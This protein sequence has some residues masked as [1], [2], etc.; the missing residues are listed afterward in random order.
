MVTFVLGIVWAPCSSWPFQDAQNSIWSWVIEHNVCCF[1]WL[2]LWFILLF[3][4]FLLVI[5]LGGWWLKLLWFYFCSPPKALTSLLV[6]LSPKHLFS[7]EP[8]S[9]F[10]WLS[11]VLD[12]GL[13]MGTWIPSF[14]WG[15]I[16]TQ[17]CCQEGA[18]YIFM[19]AWAQGYYAH[20]QCTCGT[21]IYAC[22]RTQMYMHV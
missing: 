2:M 6:P 22:I 7:Q 1:Y 15:P 17:W 4:S 8:P 3:C 21:Q 13:L 20:M 9:G 11:G 18:V 16:P 12:P 19:Y 14:P 5:F 10:S